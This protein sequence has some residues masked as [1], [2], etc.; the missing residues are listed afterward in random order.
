MGDIVHV[1]DLVVEVDLGGASSA[2]VSQHVE[3]KT[4]I[5]EEK[6]SAGA[7]VVGEVEVSDRLFTFGNFSAPKAAPVATKVE[8]QSSSS[9]DNGIDPNFP[10]KTYD[11]FVIGAGPG[12]YVGAIKASMKGLKVG[13]AEEK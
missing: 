4:E 1:G 13:I 2:H 6:K 7:S 12:G 11:L 3:S 8:T 9:S 10:G 5:V